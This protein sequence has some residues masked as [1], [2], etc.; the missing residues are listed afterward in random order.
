MLYFKTFES[1]ILVYIKKII[2]IKKIFKA[3]ISPCENKFVR[4]LERYNGK[5]Y[6]FI[7]CRAH[8]SELLALQKHC[9]S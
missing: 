8:F 1:T 6:L 7:L 3:F 4:Y 2:N 9:L 5:K